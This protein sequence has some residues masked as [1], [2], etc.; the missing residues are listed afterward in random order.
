MQPTRFSD[1]S[2][3]PPTAHHT[4]LYVLLHKPYREGRGREEIGFSGVT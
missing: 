2:T 3:R 4:P 1:G